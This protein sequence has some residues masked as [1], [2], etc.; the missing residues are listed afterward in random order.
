M[1]CYTLMEDEII[2][3]TLATMCTRKSNKETHRLAIEEQF[4]TRFL[5]FYSNYIVII[6]SAV[7]FLQ[8]ARNSL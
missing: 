2:A 7:L 4:K 5:E 1:M 6:S 3:G 8:Q